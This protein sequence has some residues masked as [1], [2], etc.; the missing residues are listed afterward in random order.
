MSALTFDQRKIHSGLYSSSTASAVGDPELWQV[1]LS[2]SRHCSFPRHPRAGAITIWLTTSRHKAGIDAFIL[3]S[4]GMAKRIPPVIRIVRIMYGG[5][6]NRACGPSS[7]LSK[8]SLCSAALH[9]LR[10]R[11]QATSAAA[12]AG[13]ISVLN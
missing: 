7:F 10:P 12:N 8:S 2:C 1:G 4:H 3:H 11:C 6:A 5:G 9:S 13:S